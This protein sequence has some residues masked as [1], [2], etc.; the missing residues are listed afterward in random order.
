MRL[1]VSEKVPAIGD[2]LTTKDCEELYEAV[3]A[4]QKNFP[5]TPEIL[6]FTL[7]MMNYGN[8]FTPVMC[9]EQEWSGTIADVSK[10]FVGKDPK[11]PNGHTLEKGLPLRL[12][13]LS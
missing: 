5:E 10:L 3:Q 11:C 4:H 8:K 9:Q 6:S 7:I 2:F 13:W 1:P 12:A